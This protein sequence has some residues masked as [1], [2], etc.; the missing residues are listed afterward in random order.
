MAALARYGKNPKEIKGIRASAKILSRVIGEVV[1]AAEEGVTLKDLDT[2]A[3]GLI[4]RE[5]AE[6]A[7]LG[8]RPGGAM[9]AYPATICASLNEVVVHG[10]PTMRRLVSGDILKIDLG[11]KL[12]GYYSDAARTIPIGK[13]S[14]AAKRLIN[15][16]RAAL[17]SAIAAAKPGGTLG[18]IGYAIKK[19]ALAN[20]LKVVKGLTGHGVGSDLHEDPVVYNEGIPGKGVLLYPGMVLAIEP[21]FSLGSDKIRQLKDESYATLDRSLSAHFEDTILITNEGREVLTVI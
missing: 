16:T 14:D 13:V 19:V 21:M 10:V 9:R 2:L 18:D 3:Y 5:G 12:N 15:G 8:Y 17:Q 6:P 20:K 1:R 11:V 7:F 4:K